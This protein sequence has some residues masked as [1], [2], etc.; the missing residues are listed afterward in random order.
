MSEKCPFQ[1]NLMDPMTHNKQ[2]PFEAF[3][4]LRDQCP[5]A[6]REPEGK[7]NEFWAITTSEH[8]DFISKNPKLFSSTTNLAHPTPGGAEIAADTLEISRQLIINMD[9]PD[10]IKFRRVVR[11]AFT[12][13]AVDALEPMMRDFAKEIIDK[14]GG[15]WGPHSFLVLRRAEPIGMTEA[16]R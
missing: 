15:H 6:L 13:K 7:H 2:L 4:T 11:N 16:R 8:I 9:P 5:V 1:F 14:I 10:H 3:K 12:A